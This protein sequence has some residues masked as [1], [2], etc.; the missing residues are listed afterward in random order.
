MDTVLPLLFVYIVP[1]HSRL[2]GH[3]VRAEGINFVKDDTVFQFRL[4]VVLLISLPKEG[5]GQVLDEGS[6]EVIVMTEDMLFVDTGYS[7]LVDIWKH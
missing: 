7:C 2:V 5:E 4:M 1:F 6:G 3:G